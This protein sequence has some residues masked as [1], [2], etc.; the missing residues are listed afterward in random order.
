MIY[1]ENLRYEIHPSIR[2]CSGVFTASSAECWEAWAATRALNDEID[3][4]SSVCLLKS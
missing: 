3:L 4:H 1:M 2:T